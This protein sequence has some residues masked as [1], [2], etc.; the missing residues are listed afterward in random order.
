MAYPKRRKQKPKIFFLVGPTAIGKSRTAIQ[1]A[2]KLDA[3]IISLDS[4]QVYRGLDILSSKPTRD[5]LKKVRHHLLDSVRPEDEFDAAAYRRLAVRKINEIHRKGKIP[6]FAGGTGLYMNVVINGIF[7]DAGKDES[8]RE[9]L[10][11]QIKTKGSRFL[12]NK[13]KRIDALAA[14]KIHPHDARRIIRALEVYRLTGRPISALWN[15]RS[16]LSDKYEIN[17]FGLNR[18]RE[19]LYNDIDRRVDEMFAQAVVDEV[20]GLLRRKLS[21][22]SGQA[23]GLK[24]IGGYLDGDYDLECAKE[25][26]KKNTRN[27]AKRQ[28]TWFR[29][30]KRIQWINIDRE[31]VIER[32]I[33]GPA[34]NLPKPVRQCLPARPAGGP[35]GRQGAASNSRSHKP[36]GANE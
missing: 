33:S 12:Y 11:T 27:Y 13:L 18:D 28:L 14:S 1:L 32:I 29:K 9:K 36:R 4:M 5:M 35:A 6:L 8:L 19:R 2:Q 26:M 24:E 25:L 7:K 3:E 15:K 16:G 22:S 10:S 21:R 20:K 31:N 34:G 30:D 17:L 23:I